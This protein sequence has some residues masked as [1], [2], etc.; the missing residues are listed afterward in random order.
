MPQNRRRSATMSLVKRALWT[1][2]LG[3][4][5]AAT[6]GAFLGW[7]QHKD[8]DPV[9][10]ELSGPYEAWQVVGCGALLAALAFETGRRGHMWL[11]STVVPVVLTGCFSVDAATDTD[12][13]GLWPVG[14]ALVAVGSF[15]GSLA[16]SALG[17]RVAQRR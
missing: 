6:Y 15:A 13:D 9:T 17:A 7:D 10:R 5:T 16:L 8:L 1:I 3:A 4:G 11:V 12:S 14:A 2:G